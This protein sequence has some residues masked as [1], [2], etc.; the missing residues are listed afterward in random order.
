[1]LLTVYPDSRIVG[2]TVS[3]L[4]KNLK[5]SGSGRYRTFVVG[6]IL[7]PGEIELSFY[8]MS[9]YDL[10]LKT[11]S[12]PTDK[13]AVSPQRSYFYCSTDDAVSRIPA[14]GG[15]PVQ[16]E[17]FSYRQSDKRNGNTGGVWVAIGRDVPPESYSEFAIEQVATEFDSAEGVLTGS[18]DVRP[19][20]FDPLRST[21][22]SDLF[23]T[24]RVEEIPTPGF[25]LPPLEP[26]LPAFICDRVGKSMEQ[27]LSNAGK[28]DVAV[29]PDKSM[30]FHVVLKSHSDREF[31]YREGYWWKAFVEITFES[32]EA[33][34][35][36][37]VSIYLYDSVVCAAPANKDPEQNGRRECFQRI[38]PSSKAEVD[39]QQRLLLVLEKAYG[40]TK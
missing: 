17:R 9:V 23:P 7:K 18:E 29:D 31:F 15:V 35:C 40:Q 5:D 33:D 6:K 20:T 10:T 8:K 19:Y 39:L 28:W 32:A 24:I 27:T 38:H 4:D 26:G 11:L 30:S 34:A 14:A 22:F 12:G 3:E 37:G 16:S 2:Y 1:M 13:C 21:V 36:S 25:G